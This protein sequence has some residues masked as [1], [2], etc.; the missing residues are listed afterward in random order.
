MVKATHLEVY[1]N[2]IKVY[3]EDGSKSLAYPSQGSVFVVSQSSGGGGGDGDF[4]WPYPL[5][6][7]TSEFGPRGTGF[8]EGMDWS[9]GPALLGEPIPAIGDGT[10]E[11]AGGAGG[12]GFGNHVIIMHGTFDGYDWKSV[13]AHMLN[14][15]P[16]TTGD[17]VSK[18]DIIGAVNNTGS[19]F[20]SHLHME[21]HRCAIGGSII[22]ANNNPSWSATRTAINPRDFM[23]AYGDGTAIIT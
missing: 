12:T 17:S 2:Q 14:L 9:G 8:H 23:N 5:D 19:S 3:Y 4:S 21:T 16:V 1:G 22:W 6:Y 20:G 7:V 13:Y 10:I 11:Y 18:G 15:P